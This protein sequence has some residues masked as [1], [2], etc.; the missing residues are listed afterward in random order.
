[1]CSLLL[2]LGKDRVDRLCLMCVRINRT[3]ERGLKIDRESI[4]QAGQV[5]DYGE[6]KRD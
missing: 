6:K 1:M 4:G 2:N 3:T 5:L